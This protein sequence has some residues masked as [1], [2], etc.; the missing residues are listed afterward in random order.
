MKK[1]VFG[2][3]LL[4]LSCSAQVESDPGPIY[5]RWV[6]DSQVG[7]GT[8]IRSPWVPAEDIKMDCH[9]NM[10]WWEKSPRRLGEQRQVHFL[11][12]RPGDICRYE[13]AQGR[14]PDDRFE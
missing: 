12:P 8:T 10:C 13:E 1:I 5:A 7:M 2:S 9:T 6:C 4:L 11:I 14:K 3:F